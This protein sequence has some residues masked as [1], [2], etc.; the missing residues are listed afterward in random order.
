MFV[1]LFVAWLLGLD[2]GISNL[3]DPSAR[4]RRSRTLKTFD[5]LSRVN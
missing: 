5:T 2:V 3:K 1:R 4:F